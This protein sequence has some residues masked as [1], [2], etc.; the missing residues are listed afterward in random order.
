MD[1]RDLL[2][3]DEL[4]KAIE[5]QRSDLLSQLATASESEAKTIRRY[6]KD[7]DK[8]LNEIAERMAGR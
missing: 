3:L 4:R 5:S 6:L 7:C 2:A 8:N 1:N